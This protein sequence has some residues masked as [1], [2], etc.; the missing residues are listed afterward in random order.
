MGGRYI[1]A[2]VTGGWHHGGERCEESGK[3]REVPRLI[4]E[5]RSQM[6]LAGGNTSGKRRKKPNLTVFSEFIRWLKQRQSLASPLP[7]TM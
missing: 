7:P 2:S 5:G 1:P 3:N 4:W 6:V